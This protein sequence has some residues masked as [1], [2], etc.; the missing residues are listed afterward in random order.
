M[1]QLV[2]VRLEGLENLRERRWASRSVAGTWLASMTILSYES[3][4]PLR[5]L[6]LG[7]L[8]FHGNLGPVE[9]PRQTGDPTSKDCSGS[10]RWNQN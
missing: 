7:G 2:P 3:S 5:D 10:L 4:R 9:T 8:S 1:P 6:A